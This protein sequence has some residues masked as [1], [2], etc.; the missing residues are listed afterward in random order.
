MTI[1]NSKKLDALRSDL[2]KALEAVTKKHGITIDI[3]TMRYS[4]DDVKVS[5][6]MRTVKAGE[7]GMSRSEADYKAACVFNPTLPKYGSRFTSRGKVYTICGYSS[8]ARKYPVLAK[9][10]NGTTYKFTVETVAK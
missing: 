5:L 8:R 10:A 6:D 2:N 7:E 9:N 1:F 3:G 4:D